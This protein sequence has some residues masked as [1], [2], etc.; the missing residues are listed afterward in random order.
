VRPAGRTD[1]GKL[2][3]ASCC[4]RFEFGLN[5]CQGNTDKAAC[6]QSLSAHPRAPLAITQATGVRLAAHRC[7]MLSGLSG[8]RA[9]AG[10]SH[11]DWQAHTWGAVSVHLACA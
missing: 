3:R 9:C 1:T 11:N 10:G 5:M 8:G 7:C 4:L 6:E 2:A